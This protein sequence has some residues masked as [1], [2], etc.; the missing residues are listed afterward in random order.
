M[1]HRLES[2]E[3]KGHGLPTVIARI[4]ATKQSQYLSIVSPEILSIIC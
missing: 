2:G 3:V 4:E 1:R